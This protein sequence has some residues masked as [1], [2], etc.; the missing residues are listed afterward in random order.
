[1]MWWRKT[2]KRASE[3]AAKAIATVIENSGTAS[4]A[5]PTAPRTKRLKAAVARKMPRT[6]WLSGWRW[7]LRIT[8]GA[9]L[10]GGEDQGDDDH[11]EADPCH[12]HRHRGDHLQHRPRRF[13]SAVEG[14][15]VG[16]LE[17]V[18]ER[19]QD[20]RRPDRR[21]DADRRKTQKVFRRRSS[22]RRT[23]VIEFP[24]PRPLLPIAVQRFG[25]MWRAGRAPG[26]TRPAGGD[27]GRD[28]VAGTVLPG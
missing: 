24:H 27:V 6:A 17:R 9:Q 28:A 1:M 4:S 26:W 20:Q 7:K 14:D 5:S 11:R 16:E 13:W 2:A 21:G 8:R 3:R 23:L 12:G 15:G 19:G 22:S 18:V 10:L 25:R